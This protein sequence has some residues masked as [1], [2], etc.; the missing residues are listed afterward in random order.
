MDQWTLVTTTWTS[1]SSNSPINVY[2][3]GD[4]TPTISGTFN[5]GD[6]R[7]NDRNVRFGGDEGRDRCINGNQGQCG[8]WEGRIL[9]T[10]EINDL[11]D[12]SRKLDH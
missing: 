8:I 3:N 2:I 9:T 12:R 11:W 5:S 6:Y 10:S 4:S 7:S 1:Y